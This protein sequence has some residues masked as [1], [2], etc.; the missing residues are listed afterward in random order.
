MLRID[1]HQ[2]SGQCTFHKV[3]SHFSLHGLLLK[4]RTPTRRKL[5]VPTYFQEHRTFYSAKISQADY[6]VMHQ[7]QMQTAGRGNASAFVQMSDHIV[8][9]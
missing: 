6:D 1:R 3:R 4:I 9:S 7:F 2:L 8:R 5:S